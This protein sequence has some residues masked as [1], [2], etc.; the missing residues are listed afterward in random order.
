M[1]PRQETVRHLS[2]AA[3]PC[4]DKLQD[5]GRY[6]RCETEAQLENDDPNTQGPAG[7][8]MPM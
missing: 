1:P 8:G 5:A 7:Q 6:I 3:Q 4:S 2:P